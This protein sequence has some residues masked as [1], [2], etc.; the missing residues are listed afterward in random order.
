MF[1][2]QVELMLVFGLY[3]LQLPTISYIP[4]KSAWNLPSLDKISIEAVYNCWW[5]LKNFNK[6]LKKSNF[7]FWLLNQFN[8]RIC[9]KYVSRKLKHQIDSNR[10]FIQNALAKWT[11][12]KLLHFQKNLKLENKSNRKHILRKQ[13]PLDVSK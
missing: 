5:L 3:V 11:I 4:L 6:V 2:A 8:V 12:E 13:N 1:A 10:K 9:G 7:F